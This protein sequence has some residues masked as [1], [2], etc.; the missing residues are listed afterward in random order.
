[1][2]REAASTPGS[3]GRAARALEGTPIYRQRSERSSSPATEPTAPGGCGAMFS[4]T[5]LHR[6]STKPAAGHSCAAITLAAV[7]QKIHLSR[8]SIFRGQLSAQGAPSNGLKLRPW[9]NRGAARRFHHQ[10]PN[11]GGRRSNEVDEAPRDDF[12]FSFLAAFRRGL[13]VIGADSGASIV[14]DRHKPNFAVV[15]RHTPYPTARLSGTL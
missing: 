13:E 12:C 15:D 1:M 3:I 7:R 11:I 2:S 14:I 6:K 8:C 5:G 9:D 4:R 10:T